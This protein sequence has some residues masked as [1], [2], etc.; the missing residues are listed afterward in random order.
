M[1]AATPRTTQALHPARASLAALGCAVALGWAAGCQTYPYD[2]L[3]ATRAYPAQLPQQEVVEIQVIPDVNNGT[4]T[5]VNATA[6]S[7]KAFDL[8][9][10]RRYVRHVDELL[11][12][13]TLVLSIDTFWD[14]RGEGPFPGGWFRYYQPTP[15]VLAQIQTDEKSPLIGLSATRPVTVNR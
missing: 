5:I 13:Q 1:S 6:T 7:Y 12:G 10:N 11:A 15:I 4:I 8:W 14:E 9:I 2:P 3:K